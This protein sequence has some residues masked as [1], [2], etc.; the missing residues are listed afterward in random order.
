M[1]I[2]ALSYCR[3]TWQD[4]QH[5]RIALQIFNDERFV[6][7]YRHREVVHI[8]GG[9]LAAGTF[10]RARQELSAAGFPELPPIDE[11]APGQHPMELGWLCDRRWQ[12]AETLD[13]QRFMRFII[14]TSTVLSVL[15][16]DLARM[17]PGETTPVIEQGRF[18]PRSIT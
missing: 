12:R 8:W 9:R 10:A 18:D 14:L 5:G 11:L 3:G 7:T 13:R 6:A 15:D 1:E 4:P 17:P 16:S 2:E